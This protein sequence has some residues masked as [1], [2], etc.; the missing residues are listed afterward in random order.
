MCSGLTQPLAHPILGAAMLKRRL[1]HASTDGPAHGTGPGAPAAADRFD[2]L[3]TVL[4]AQALARLRELDPTGATGLLERVL[5]AFETSLE[6]LLAQLAE[7]RRTNDHATMRHVAHTLKS[8]AASVGALELSRIC[9]DIERR[10]REQQTE[11]LGGLL[12][13]M[14]AQ[15][16]RVRAVLKPLLDAT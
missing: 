1:P 5:R 3:T 13:D 15:G 10:V 4:D 12:D 7:A 16:D 8:S 9:A 6:R 2:T 14:V 11:G